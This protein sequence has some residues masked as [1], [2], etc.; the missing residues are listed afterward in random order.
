MTDYLVNFVNYLNPNGPTVDL[1]W[2]KYTNASTN[3][4]TFTGESAPFQL[5]ITQDDFRVAAMNE[6]TELSLEYPL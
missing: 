1:S 5:N 6:V 4:L 2:P 3:L